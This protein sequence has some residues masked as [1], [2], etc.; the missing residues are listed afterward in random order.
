MR[1]KPLNWEYNETTTRWCATCI[2]GVYYRW[3]RNW[4]L[5]NGMVLQSY[6]EAGATDAAQADYD[7]IV[8]SA[9]EDDLLLEPGAGGW[10]YR[11]NY[12]PDGEENW[13]N[14]IAPDGKVVANIRTNYA[15][16][17]VDGMN[18]PAGTA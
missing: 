18:R 14:L 13:A 15:R 9:I 17:I 8:R 4:C 10:N 16:A 1:V 5:G 6:D 2:V 12:G 3:G 7:R 11:I